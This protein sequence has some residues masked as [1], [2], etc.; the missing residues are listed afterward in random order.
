MSGDNTEQAEDLSFHFPTSNSKAEATLDTS[1]KGLLRTHARALSLSQRKGQK[2]STS[3]LSESDCKLALVLRLVN[4]TY[5]SIHRLKRGPFLSAMQVMEWFDEDGDGVVSAGEFVKRM[6]IRM[7]SCNASNEKNALRIKNDFSLKKRLAHTRQLVRSVRDNLMDALEGNGHRTDTIILSHV[8]KAL[9][10]FVDAFDHLGHERLI[11]HRFLELSECIV[12]F[13]MSALITRSGYRALDLMRSQVEDDA[14]TLI[15]RWYKT[16][17]TPRRK[18]GSGS[19]FWSKMLRR[20][21]ERERMQAKLRARREMS[22]RALEKANNQKLKATRRLQTFFRAELAKN[23]RLL[24]SGDNTENKSLEAGSSTGIPNIHHD[25]AKQAEDNVFDAHKHKLLINTS[26]SARMTREKREKELKRYMRDPFVHGF[27]GY[28]NPRAPV[29][30]DFSG[31]CEK[32]SVR[33]KQDETNVRKEIEPRREDKFYKC[34]RSS[35]RPAMLANRS[36]RLVPKRP[37]T[38]RGRR[39]SISLRERGN[40]NRPIRPSSAMVQ[41]H[42]DEALGMCERLHLSKFKKKEKQLRVYTQPIS[43]VKRQRLMRAKAK[44]NSKS[45]SVCGG[46][47]ADVTNVSKSSMMYVSACV[48]ENK[49]VL[50]RMPNFYRTR[51][52]RKSLN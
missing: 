38:S 5:A 10:A 13:P 30:S 9:K 28:R 41:G 25:A 23:R 6:N 48:A 21:T 50:L 24:E 45:I 26:T 36:N 8:R 18:S 20:M 32:I 47:V 44:S 49:S 16:R 12:R 27:L 2:I 19:V 7:P 31:G 15:A 22:S 34:D 37:W 51:K 3:G 33:A 52:L 46:S 4:E 39:A 43:S 42:R 17:G 35:I 29:L 40:E 1:K 14:A 11:N